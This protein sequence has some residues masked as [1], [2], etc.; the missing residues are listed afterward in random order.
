MGWPINNGDWDRATTPPG[1]SAADITTILAALCLGVNERR[2]ARGLTETQFHYTE[3]LDV[4]KARPVAAD[5]SGR[6]NGPLAPAILNELYTAIVSSDGWYHSTAFDWDD[7]TTGAE[8]WTEAGTGLDAFDAD[9]GFLYAA[10]LLHLKRALDLQTLCQTPN[11]N[12]NLDAIYTIKRGDTWPPN[13]L[14][15]TIPVLGNND[16]NFGSGGVDETGIRLFKTRTTS[17]SHTFTDLLGIVKGRMGVTGFE[18]DNWRVTVNGNSFTAQDAVEQ[19][20]ITGT[21]FW[22]PL[23]ALSQ[24]MTFNLELINSS[25]PVDPPNI[26]SYNSYLFFNPS[27]LVYQDLSSILTDQS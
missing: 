26:Y 6:F 20:P 23:F 24:S 13:E 5:F 18:P 8:I 21:T 19:L 10:N 4:T 2:V 9:R 1:A 11:T 17:T 25:Q 7:Y 15:E 22:S 14:S 16:G 27:L 12:W 3:A